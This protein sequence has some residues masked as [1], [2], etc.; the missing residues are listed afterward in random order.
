MSALK[1]QHNN[2]HLL[3]TELLVGSQTGHHSVSTLG[4]PHLENKKGKSIIR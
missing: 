4:F 3:T 1:D 2:S